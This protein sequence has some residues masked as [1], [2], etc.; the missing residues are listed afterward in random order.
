MGMGVGH[1]EGVAG[2]GLHEDGWA[3][4]SWV[5]HHRVHQVAHAQAATGKERFGLLLVLLPQHFTLL[6][7]PAGYKKRRIKTITIMC[8]PAG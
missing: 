7:M 5:G 2:Q 4:V 1:V 3:D 6:C 8:M